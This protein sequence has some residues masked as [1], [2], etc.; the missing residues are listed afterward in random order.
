M[1]EKYVEKFTK[2]LL[3]ALKE[4][5]V[6]DAE[7]TAAS[8]RK[9]IA[10]MYASDLYKKHNIYPTMNVPYVY[11][12]IAMCLELRELGMSDD[13]IMDTVNTAYRARKEFFRKLIY[14]VN[15]LPNTYKIAKKWNIS[16]HDK[17]VKDGSITYDLFTVSDEKIEYSISKCMYVEMFETYG[18]RKLCKIFCITDENAYA[19][20]TRGVRFVR[21]SDLSNGDCCHD[22]VINRKYTG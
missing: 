2:L 14:C 3:C 1:E 4:K 19:G 10:D 16:D 11:G 21:H 13:E 20:L 6:P 22:E 15:L 8:Y 9:R 7:R 17:R 5:G 18:I 12:V